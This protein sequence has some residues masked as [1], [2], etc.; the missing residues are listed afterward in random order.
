MAETIA[1]KTGYVYEYK[2]HMSDMM[3][4]SLISPHRHSGAVMVVVDWDGRGKWPGSISVYRDTSG[5]LDEL[6][7]A[8][9]VIKAV[10]NSVPACRWKFS[11]IHHAL[12]L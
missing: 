6:R 1:E 10:L 8:H 3:T 5:K 12:D 4:F 9:E 11:V 2:I 7:N